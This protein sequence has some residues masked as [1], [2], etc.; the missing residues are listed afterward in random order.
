SSDGQT[1]TLTSRPGPR[2][3]SGATKLF[4]SRKQGCRVGA[5]GLLAI[6]AVAACSSTSTGSGT[7]A[8]GPSPGGSHHSSGALALRSA[9][10]AT[11]RTERG[12]YRPVDPTPR[13]AATGKRIVVIAAGQAGQQESEAAVA[14]A[15]AIGWK[16]DLFNANGDTGN[17]PGL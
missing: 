1:A 11:A 6:S 17:Y 15:K 14:A 12:T 13:P 7:S 3:G 8:G 5:I 10:A 2:T 16:V 9:V 4:I